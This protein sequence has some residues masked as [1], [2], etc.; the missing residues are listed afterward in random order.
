MGRN[1]GE[2]REERIG[3]GEERRARLPPLHTSFIIVNYSYIFGLEV[4][5]WRKDRD[6]KRAREKKQRE[7]GGE[8]GDIQAAVQSNKAKNVFC[9]VGLHRGCPTSVMRTSWINGK[10]I[11]RE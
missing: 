4:R 11:K 3:E 6:R 1:R 8:G 9:V 10:N 2:R 7:G 5:E